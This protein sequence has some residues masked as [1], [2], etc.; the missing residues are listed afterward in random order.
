MYIDFNYSTA[1]SFVSLTYCI[2]GI[3]RSVQCI[4]D[5]LTHQRLQVA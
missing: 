4:L 3:V 5:M 1:E 2:N